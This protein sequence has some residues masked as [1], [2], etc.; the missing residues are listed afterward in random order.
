MLYSKAVVTMS[1][2]WG[3]RKI[4]PKQS[5]REDIGY[6]QGIETKCLFCVQCGGDVLVSTCVVPLHVDLYART[7]GGQRSTLG[8][9][10]QDCISYTGTWSSPIRRCCLTTEP[11][12]FVSLYHHGLLECASIP[13]FSC[14]VRRR[15]L[16][17]MLVQQPAELSL[18]YHIL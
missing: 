14:G 10:P 17:L 6:L 7:C 4:V 11:Q 18:L 2:V 8:R 13:G 15:D 12:G 1:S 3:Q 9:A 5:F 16:G